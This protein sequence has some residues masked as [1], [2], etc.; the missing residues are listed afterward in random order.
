MLKTCLFSAM[1]LV[2]FLAT[3]LAT[4]ALPT[5][6]P[7]KIYGLA[8]TD[9]I[10]WEKGISIAD[11]IGANDDERVAAAIAK[12]GAEGGVIFFP[13]GVYNFK[14]TIKIPSGIVLRGD[15]PA[16]GGNNLGGIDATNGEYNLS[17]HFDFPQY[18]P[19]F[20]GDG[21]PNN[22]AFK[23]IELADPIGGTNCGVVSI[24]INHGHIELGT[25]ANF[26]KNYTAGTL[27]K[28]IIVFGN[29]LRNAAVLDTSIPMKVS[30]STKSPF[31][32]GWQRWTQR[33][34]AAIHVYSGANILVGNN[35]IPESGDDNFVMKGYKLYQRTL[36]GTGI[37]D[38]KLKMLSADITFDYDNRPGV[39]VNAM[40]TNKDFDVWNP[41]T[42]KDG[43]TPEPA[44]GSMCRGI[45]IRNNYIFNTGCY[46]MN[47]TGDGA[48][49]AFNK[50]YIKPNVVRPTARGY[51]FDYFTNN[52]RAIELRGFRWIVEGN[53]YEVYSNVVADV[54]DVTK[55]TNERY[56]DGEG[57]MHESINNCEVR[58]SALINNTG[59]GYLCIW[60]VPVRGLEIRGNIVP[61]IVILAR[62]NV[63]GGNV[64]MPVSNLKITGNT[65]YEV[66]KMSLLPS[67]FGRGIVI[68]GGAGEGN[69]VT[70]NKT[71]SVGGILTL[72]LTSPIEA[73]NNDSFNIVKK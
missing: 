32:E 3:M 6:N 58:D 18:K 22:T 23:G 31:Q 51:Q 63:A 34:H 2:T 37:K 44:A 60:R 64:G 61:N 70:D 66:G 26:G 36:E 5:D 40:G 69:I 45:V 65:T 46:G 13:A 47:V 42:T 14:E 12:L 72:N 67:F 39:V 29:I 43:V 24:D 30:P 25:S 7:T 9:E 15:A 1:L 50:I 71:S 73:R 35:R 17:T 48:Y 21:T 38:P 11:V 19:T 33:H 27:G 54:N 4:S 10:M 28:N 57:I 68:T 52:N 59:N 41:Y 20:V 62:T 49:I 8:W 53:Y 55:G 56:G 16:Y